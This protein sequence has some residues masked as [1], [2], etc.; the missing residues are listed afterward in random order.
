MDAYVVELRALPAPDTSNRQCGRGG[1]PVC[2]RRSPKG[3]RRH[4]AGP[5]EPSPP[6]ATAE[7]RAGRSCCRG[8]GIS[9]AS[10]STSSQRRVV[11]SPHRHPVSISSRS[12]AAACTGSR[13]S[14]SS[15]SST[16]PRRRNSS[17]VRN[18]S[19]LRVSVLGHKRGRDCRR[20]EPD[21]RLRPDRA[22]VTAR[23]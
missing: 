9:F 14:A 13:P 21:P 1:C 7:P 5:P 20:A 19:S 15:V 18:R 11:I 12:A 22:S 2:V 16:C 10:R 6:P 8:A 3:C 4:A 23:R 17:S